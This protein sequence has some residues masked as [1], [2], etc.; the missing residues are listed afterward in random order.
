MVELNFD[1]SVFWDRPF[2]VTLTGAEMRMLFTGAVRYAMHRGTGGAHMTADAVRAHLADLDEG[3]LEIIA[4]DIR[5]EAEAWGEGS[6]GR[7]AALPGEIDRELER[8]GH[9][10]D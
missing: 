1:T 8:R 2:P 6:V 3:T 5:H 9:G 4:R 7:F 10:G